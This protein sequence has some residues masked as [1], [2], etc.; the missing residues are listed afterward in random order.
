MKRR[1]IALSMWE[2]AKAASIVEVAIE[3]HQLFCAEQEWLK[4]LDR[5]RQVNFN[6][7]TSV[8]WG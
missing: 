2:K 7:L 5:L 4:E 1:R 6:D 3:Y 8:P